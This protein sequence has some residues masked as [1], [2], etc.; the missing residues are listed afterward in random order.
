MIK[1]ICDL[2]SK[3]LKFMGI[4]ND[5]EILFRCVDNNCENGYDDTVYPLSIIDDCNIID[6]NIDKNKTLNILE[7]EGRNNDF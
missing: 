4:A 2:C 6:T 7:K 3:D 1:L 5:G